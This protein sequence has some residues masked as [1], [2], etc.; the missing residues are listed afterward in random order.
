MKK[1]NLTANQAGDTLVEVM[2]ATAI[3]SLVLAGAFTI[4]NRATRINQT[5]NERTQVS[6]LMQ[7]E[8]ELIRASRDNDKATHWAGV[9]ARSNVSENSAFCEGTGSNE[10]T[11]AFYMEDDLTITDIQNDPSGKMIDYEP[12]DLFDIWVE[13]VDGP[14]PVVVYTDFFVYGCWEG[15]GGEG[16]QRSGLVMRLER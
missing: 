3:L 11:A 15:I 14:G 2:L 16:L 5:A 4:S 10:S 7:R 8:A 6:N 12:T 9:D 13:A 1:L